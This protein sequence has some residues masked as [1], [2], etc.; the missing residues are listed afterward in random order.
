MRFT[1]TEEQQELRRLLRRFLDERSPA[2]AA[3]AALDGGYDRA[4]W[5]ALATDL[6][7]HSMAVPEELGGQGWGLVELALAMEELGRVAY[8]GPFLASGVLAARALVR[9]GAAEALEPL[10]TGDRVVGL[11]AAD[12][13]GAWRPEAVQTVFDGAAVSGAKRLVVSA[14][15]CDELLV[16]ARRP[17]T[18][19]ADGLV[20]L[21]VDLGAPGVKLE[22]LDGLDRNR[23]Q[24]DVVLEGAAARLLAED[25]GPAIARA[26]DEAGACLAAELV[27][28]AQAC[29]DL[30]VE[31]GKTRQ[32]FGVPIGSFQAFKHRCADLLVDLE[33]ARSAA[34]VAACRAT[35]DDPS[36]LAEATSVAL[37]VCGDAAARVGKETVQLHGGIGFT[38]EHDAHVY[39]RRIQSARQ[40]L[41]TPSWHRQRVWA[42]TE[43]HKGVG[44]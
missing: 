31:Y 34:Y 22:H 21:A 13:G 16:V 20:L 44:A 26:L 9:V 39:V 25:V 6:G 23:P 2:A 32:Q 15:Q 40:L 42:L 29:L 4:V 43:E 7:L 17:G 38:W 12:D 14:E 19:G 3:R 18:S 5:N 11:A 41:G 35:E 30:T 28:A 36:A 1:L 33:H 24:A 37:A 27:G 10:L 8:P